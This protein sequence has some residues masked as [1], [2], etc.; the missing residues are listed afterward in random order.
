MAI[1]TIT[2]LRNRSD[3]VRDEITDE[4][5]SSV[6]VGQ[7]LRDIIDTFRQRTLQVGEESVIVDSNRLGDAISDADD[8][9]FIICGLQ[10]NFDF[11]TVDIPANTRITLILMSDVS[12]FPQVSIPSSFYVNQAIID[13]GHN[14]SIDSQT[15]YKFDI[16]HHTINLTKL[17]SMNL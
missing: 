9:S 2:N 4:K 3:E 1:D 14:I 10:D 12:P 17:I 8:N 6:R 16:F 15:A 11:A 13:D 5:N 7:L